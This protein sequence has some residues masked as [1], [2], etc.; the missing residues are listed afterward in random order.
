VFGLKTADATAYAAAALVLVVSF[1]AAWFPARR[2]M[3]TDPVIA[4]RED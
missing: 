3:R 4:L 1:V 2:V